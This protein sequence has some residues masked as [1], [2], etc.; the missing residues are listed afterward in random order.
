MNFFSFLQVTL[1]LIPSSEYPCEPQLVKGYLT[2]KVCFN[3]PMGPKLFI[4]WINQ[5]KLPITWCRYWPQVEI[6]R[7]CVKINWWNWSK[8]VCCEKRFVLLFVKQELN[9]L[10]CAVLLTETTTY[11][12][13]FELYLSGCLR[14]VKYRSLWG[15]DCLLR[16]MCIMLKQSLF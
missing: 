1:F 6:W 12:I 11:M 10:L 4:A 8:N 9:L 14:Q 15:K 13:F 7:L 2:W 5:K 3:S 16:Q